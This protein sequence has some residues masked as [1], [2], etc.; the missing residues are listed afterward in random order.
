M[1]HRK[2]EEE[3]SQGEKH[4]KSCVWHAKEKAD[5]FAMSASVNMVVILPLEFKALSDDDEE[6][7]VV[8][9]LNLDPMHAAF[10]K[11]EHKEH[12]HLRLLYIKG[13]VDGHPMTKML[14]E[15]GAAVNI[16]SYVTYQKLGKGEKDVIKTDMMLKEFEG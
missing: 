6:E 3:R 9:K 4:V 13:Y 16:M 15:G 8:A 7:P 11:P 10:D 2:Q 14:V 5:E 12:W 1:H